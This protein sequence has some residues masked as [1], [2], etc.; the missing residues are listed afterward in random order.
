MAL[1]V[2]EH[3]L[4]LLN[5]I[6]AAL[7]HVPC[8]VSQ[9]AIDVR[10]QVIGPSWSFSARFDETNFNEVREARACFRFRFLDQSRGASGRQ[11]ALEPQ[12]VHE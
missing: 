3:H 8:L 4:L 10:G 11:A 1:R 9:P 7:A 6:E 2:L 12:F 5:T